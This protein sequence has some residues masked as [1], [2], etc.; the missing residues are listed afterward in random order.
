MK[1]T[2]NISGMTCEACEY[3]IQYV[4]SQIPSVKSVIAKFLDNS[5]EIESDEKISENNIKE[6]LK[7]HTKYALITPLSVGEGAGVRVRLQ[8][9]ANPDLQPE[10]NRNAFLTQQEKN[11]SWI[12]QY[13]PLLLIVGFITLVSLL[14]SI[15]S[16]SGGWGAFLHNFMTG[17]FLVFSFFKLLD[18]KAFA[19]SFQMYDLLAA[20]V[21]VYGKIYPFIELALGLLC[22]IHYQE[23][24]VYIADIVIMAF[25]A[26]GVIQ[27]VLDKRKIRCACLG[28]VFNLPMSTVTIIENSVMVIIGIVLLIT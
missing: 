14:T 17:F 26:L 15:N 7:P 3:K 2:I 25:G 4:F 6:I 24:Y 28:S 10:L 13:Y 22:L 9:I 19:E 27:S 16:P 8:S 23:K 11:Q 5:V 1:Q 18:V 20:K 21:P 12:S